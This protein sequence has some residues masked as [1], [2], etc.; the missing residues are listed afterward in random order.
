MAGEAAPSP[1]A[2]LTKMMSALVVLRDHPL[3]VGASGPDITVTTADVA[4]YTSELAANDSVVKVGTGEQLSE[5]QLLE[6]ALIPSGDNIIQLLATWDAGS[7]SA[8]ATRMN[9]LARTLGMGHTL[10]VG[11]SGVDPATVSTVSDQLR[12]AEAAMA[13]PVFAGI[14]S[15]PQVTLP[16]AGVQ[17]NVDADLGS[18]GIDGIKTGWVPQGGGCF[19]FAATNDFLGRKVSIVGGVLGERGATPIPTAFSTAENLVAAT[20]RALRSFRLPTGTTIGTLTA[21]YTSPI[22]V[23]SLSPVSLIAWSGAQIQVSLRGAR[24]GRGVPETMSDVGSLRIELGRSVEMTKLS[25]TKQLQH[26]S[27]SWRLTHL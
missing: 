9:A 3:S 10:Y 20:E 17:Y 14:V 21:P 13:N 24:A 18:D 26:P 4:N 8:F 7:T 1:I 25:V 11:P 5:L 16:V 2:S 12:L 27:F 15:M 19:V 6:G 22:R 23:V